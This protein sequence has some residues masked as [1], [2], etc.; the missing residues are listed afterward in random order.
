M[1]ETKAN[2]V[3]G[4]TQKEDPEVTR[5]QVY[6]EKGCPT[7]GTDGRLIARLIDEAKKTADYKLLGTT[8]KAFI[9]LPTMGSYFRKLIVFTW[10]NKPN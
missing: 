6:I 5:W 9:M 1:T 10:A 8:Q 4:G 2:A 3:F 7:A